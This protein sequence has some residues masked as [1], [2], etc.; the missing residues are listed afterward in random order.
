MSKC[1]IYP[2]YHVEQRNPGARAFPPAR[3][4][5]RM[6]GRGS[7]IGGC[8]GRNRGRRGE[9]GRERERKRGKREENREREEGRQRRRG[10]YTIAFNQMQHIGMSQ[11]AQDINYYL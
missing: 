5:R 4:A 11:G 3:N 7:R 1:S 10:E 9:K 8:G 6:D 2:L